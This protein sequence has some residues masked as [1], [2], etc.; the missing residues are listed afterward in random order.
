MRSVPISPKSGAT[1]GPLPFTAWQLAQFARARKQGLP[2]RRV[3]NHRTARIEAAHVAKVG[4]D[5]GQLGSAKG[6]RLHRGAG[7]AVGDRGA[8]IVVGNNALE[9]ARAKVDAGN[10]IAGRAV[11]CGAL[12]GENLRAILN[13]GLK[14]FRRSILALS[15]GGWS[16]KWKKPNAIAHSNR[17]RAWYS[18]RIFTEGPPLV[19]EFSV[20]NIQF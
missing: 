19:P 13:I 9:L 10:Q 8:Q 7:D 20:L 2:A 17:L 18:H 11:A 15:E 12:S 6:E 1:R 16:V 3:A 4:N 14:I 5:S